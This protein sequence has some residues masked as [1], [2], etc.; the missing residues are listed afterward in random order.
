MNAE[1]SFGVAEMRTHAAV[2]A[3]LCVAW[4]K[5]NQTR[6][7]DADKKLAGFRGRLCVRCLSYNGVARTLSQL[8][9]RFAI[10]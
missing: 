1:G 4:C 5:K 10:S 2:P 9:E 7:D 8:W 6:R 3:V